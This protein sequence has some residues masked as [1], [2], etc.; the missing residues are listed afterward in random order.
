M[1]WWITAVTLIATLPCSLLAAEPGLTIFP[2]GTVRLNGVVMNRTSNLLPGDRV[3][4]TENSAATLTSTGTSV[5]LASRSSAT[6]VPG[7]I[8]ITDGAA[9]FSTNSGMKARVRNITVEG[10]TRETRFHVGERA[11]KIYIAALT[12]KLRISDGRAETM[13]DAG[14]AIM[15]PVPAATKAESPEPPP[16]NGNVSNAVAIGVN[17]AVVALGIV[18]T[19]VLSDHISPNPASPS[20]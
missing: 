8:A 12:G 1:R 5:Q 15:I 7:E 6:F 9:S 18:L 14:H 2:S 10:A 20:Q 13:L 17:V 4:T 16:P 11:N 19:K 3:E